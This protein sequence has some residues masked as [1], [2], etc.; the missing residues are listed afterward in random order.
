MVNT[1]PLLSTASAAAKRPLSL[2]NKPISF[3]MASI[4][5]SALASSHSPYSLPNWTRLAADDAEHDADNTAASEGANVASLRHNFSNN[6]D[7][8]I[9]M[10]MEPTYSTPHEASAAYQAGLLKSDL[11]ISS[12]HPSIRLAF[13]YIHT[14]ER[15]G[16]SDDLKGD[17][18]DNNLFLCWVRQD[19]V[20]CHFRTLRPIRNDSSTAAAVMGDED[21][22]N[23]A[24]EGEHHGSLRGTSN[25]LME[26][27]QSL[28]HNDTTTMLVS[29]HDT[30]ETTFPG[31]AFVFC[32]RVEYDH[33]GTN[34]DNNNQTRNENNDLIVL[35]NDEKTYFLRKRKCDGEDGE[36]K[37]AS[38][39]VWE[40]Y[41]VV[42]GFRPGPMPEMME[43]ESGSSEQDNMENNDENNEEG[44]REESDDE[45]DDDSFDGRELRVQLV[46]IQ[47]VRASKINATNSETETDDDDLPSKVMGC[48]DCTQ[49]VPFLRGAMN[50]KPHHTPAFV[51]TKSNEGGVDSALELPPRDENQTV[52]EY[53][54]DV[55]VCITQL[56]PTPLDTSSK[57]YDEVIL[58]GWPCRTEPGCFP[59][60]MDVPENGR[61][62]LRSRFEADLIAASNA[63]P[64]E[65]REKLIASTPIWINKSQSFGPKAAP[66]KARDGCF[67]PGSKWLRRNGMNPA[68]CGGVEWYDAKHYLSDCDLWGPGGL[69][70]HELSHAWHCL[71]IENGYDN[72]DIKDVYEKAM[73]DGLY[74]CVPV[75]GPQGPRCKAYACQDQM[76]FFAELSVA[77]LG[78]LD[79]REHNKWYPFNRAQLR[80]HDPRAF[81]ML[82]RMWGVED[83]GLRDNKTT[84]R[85]DSGEASKES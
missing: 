28:P 23:G 6:A 54:L 24:V 34:G 68:K 81:A 22:I 32:R 50:P 15:S 25:D 31:H 14:D 44:K 10:T 62:L 7:R 65:A 38:E 75:H 1:A 5:Q 71:H 16:K 4:A 21:A 83:D 11:S 56:D 55:T 27:S 49:S 3:N 40:A 74:D 79:D 70:L 73:E 36:S 42:G 63:L 17:D 18:E 39:D 30:V 84:G 52:E 37:N 60:D 35:N 19:G 77:F 41:L 69:Q 45:S 13:R 82:C 53:A 61:N 29:E 64:T 47:S 43:G 78:G 8:T 12:N 26:Q 67:H 72:E 76:E 58:G 2:I 85:G 9:A 57:H 80:E 59:A 66:I 51:A 46:K 33:S 48:S 20:P